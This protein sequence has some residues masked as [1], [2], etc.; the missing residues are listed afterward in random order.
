MSTPPANCASFTAWYAEVQAR[1]AALRDAL[2]ACPNLFMPAQ[3]IEAIEE[4]DY[5]AVTIEAELGAIA[6]RAAAWAS[7][8][9]VE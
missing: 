4:I 7:P 8:E 6:K 2:G 1:F 9:G 3:I 5:A